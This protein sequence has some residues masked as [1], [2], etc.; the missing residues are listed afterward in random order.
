MPDLGGRNVSECI[1]ALLDAGRAGSSGPG[2]IFCGPREW[3]PEAHD[4][5]ARLSFCGSGEQPAFAQHLLCPDSF[6]R[7]TRGG[8]LDVSTFSFSSCASAPRTVGLRFSLRAVPRPPR[9]RGCYDATVDSAMCAHDRTLQ[10]PRAQVMLELAI[11]RRTH[12]A[13][14]PFC[15]LGS[16]TAKRVRK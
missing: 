16:R 14:L 5:R 15:R 13:L 1:N 9:R 3:A 7:R 12:S 8:D 11:G 10:T 4:A 2:L 6:A